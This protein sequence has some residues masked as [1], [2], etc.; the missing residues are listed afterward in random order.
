[1]NPVLERPGYH[2]ALQHPIVSRRRDGRPGF[3]FVSPPPR[4][5]SS[6]LPHGQTADGVTVLSP[7][8]RFPV[9]RLSD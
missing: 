2:P 4:F 8:L 7:I 6:R 9:S 3:Q 1:M 5:L